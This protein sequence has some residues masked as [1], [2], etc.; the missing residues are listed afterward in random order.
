M[1]KVVLISAVALTLGGCQTI[2]TGVAAIASAD[3]RLRDKCNYLNSGVAIAQLAVG[4]V[5]KAQ[6]YVDQ[7]TALAD[8]YCTGAPIT[9]LASAMAAMERVIVAIRPVAAKIGS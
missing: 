8:A 4:F 5:P 9:D 6:R 3:A 7:G 2:N 1:K